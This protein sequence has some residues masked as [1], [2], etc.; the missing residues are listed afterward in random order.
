VTALAEPKFAARQEAE[1]ELEALGDLAGP[2][3]REALQGDP[4]L[5]LRQRVERLLARSR[6]PVPAG[7]PIREV[8]AIELLE[9]IGGDD[10]RGALDT[11][12]GGAAEA[13]STRDARAAVA[14][15]A[16]RANEMP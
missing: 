10:A 9:W 14:R 3:L 12:A 5:A 2:A 15:L 13:R 16:A 1:K 8:R 11:M 6:G 7:A 4:P